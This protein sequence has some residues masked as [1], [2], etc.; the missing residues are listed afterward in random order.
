MVIVHLS[1]AVLP[2]ANPVTVLVF[3][4]G[5]VIVT[6]PLT[7]LHKPVPVVAAKPAKVKFP[8]LH[9]VMSEPAIVLPLGAAGA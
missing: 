6:A 3:D 8:L 2:E 4:V 7:T 5:V 1:V 9:C